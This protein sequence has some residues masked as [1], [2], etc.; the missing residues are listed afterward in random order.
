MLKS[1]KL[2]ENIPIYKTDEYFEDWILKI[3]SNE[4]LFGPSERVLERFKNLSSKNFQF[5]PC[6]GV[7]LDELAALHKVK[8][9]NLILT[10]GC[11]EAINI[12]LNTYLEYGDKV[13]SF[14]PTFAMPQIYTKACGGEFVEVEY[15]GRW[16]FN[17]DKL[18]A[19]AERV[20]PR[21]ILITSPNSPTGEVVDENDIIKILRTFPQILLLLDNTYINYSDTEY[22]FAS[23]IENYPN[24]FVVKS[25]SKDYALAG[26]RLGYV[27]SKNTD[28]LRKVISPYSVNTL[29]VL[30]GVESLKD[31]EHFAK[32]KEEVK[33]SKELM[34][35][36]LKK[37]GYS[38][39]KSETN[40][41]LCDFGEKSDFIYNKLLLNRI[42]VK[43]FGKTKY[44][45][46]CFRITIP[47]IKD[48]EFFLKTLEP[49]ELLVFD[50]D[51]VV[52]DVRNSYRAAIEKTFEHFSGKTL[53][54]GAIQNAKN[55]G[56]LNCDWDLTKY[57]LEK[58]G[59]NVE[60]DEVM[61]VF[62]E[63]FFDKTKEGRKG[64]I[65]D[66]ELILDKELLKTL[67]EKYDFAVFTGRPEEE[68]LYSLKKNGI[69]KYFNI[70]I[71]KDCLPFDR[72][73]PWPDGL[74][75]IKKSGTYTKITYFGDTAD[76]MKTAKAAGVCAV[77]VLPPQDKSGSLKEQLKQSG[78]ETVVDNINEILKK[79]NWICV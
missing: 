22:D 10:N 32:I 44:I 72:Q 42:K 78:A 70:V 17:A 45:E 39:Y 54:A 58:A 74:E 15:D 62:Q 25:F 65:D 68:A 37:L 12:V 14:S 43:Y 66:E 46:N 53:E 60:L 40:F 63:H 50:L 26:L 20:K 29:A 36:G 55:S 41:L 18:I 77:G 34:Y 13:L 57:L 33:A 2:L 11:D 24:L 67:S 48:T 51:G 73:K 76:D 59:I 3:D 8:K 47:S 9:G 21:I 69:L 38:P 56:G 19:E 28:E 75:L 49:K 31:K 64:L 52:F 6:Y 27:V 16:T 7:L 4:N 1:K 35:S 79:E 5:Y 71:S 61:K 30:A 23:L